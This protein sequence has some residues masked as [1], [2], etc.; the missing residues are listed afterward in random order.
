MTKVFLSLLY[1]ELLLFYRDKRT[2]LHALAFFLIVALL[3]PIAL[4]PFPELLR[5]FAPGIVWVAA[6]LS[7]LLALENW[8]RSDLED[9][10][11]EQLLL[12]T[13][14]LSTVVAAKI[15]AFWLASALPLIVA[16]PLLGLLLHL[17]GKEILILMASLLSGTPALIA[18][19]ATC[20][21]LTLQLQQSGALLGLLVLPLCLPILLMGINTLMQAQLSLP[22]LGNLAFLSGL[23]LIGFA[24]LPIAIACALRW[25]MEI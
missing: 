15:L 10:A 2:F 21:T 20:K 3:F 16:T 4:S 11:L 12:S 14:P 7:T 24:L 18:I 5:K 6:L 23:S 13:C 25:G 8:L 22:V 9:Q 17:S 19:G 1:F